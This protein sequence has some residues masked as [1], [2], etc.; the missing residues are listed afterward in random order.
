MADLLNKGS[1]PGSTQTLQRRVRELSML[2]DIARAVISVLDL[3]GVLNRIVDA[4]VFLTNAEEGFILLVDEE[5]DEFILR[6]GKGLGDKAAKVMRMKVKDTMAG[7]VVQTGQPLRIGGF[8]K[9]QEYKVKT[10]Y[11][12]KSLVNVP[13]KAQSRQVI[14]VLSVDH[15]LASMRT[16]SDHDVALLTS[17]ADYAAIAIENARLYEEANERAEYLANALEE[18]GQ[19]P[20]KPSVESDREDLEKFIQGLRAQREEV[21]FVQNRTVKMSQELR[22]QAN[23]VD[24]MSQRLALWDEEVNALMPALEWLAE[25][26]LTLAAGTDRTG[27]LPAASGEASPTLALS[28]QLTC[29]L[30]EGILL[31]DAKGQ[32][33]NANP[34]A[35]RL[36]DRSIEEIEG[37]DL[38]K[39]AVQ[40]SR[41]ERMVGSLRLALALGDSERPAP[42]S[43]SATLYF[44]GRAV[45]ATLVPFLDDEADNPV[46]IVAVLRDITAEIEGWRA[47]DEAIGELSE[48]IRSPLTAIASYSDLLLSESV[49]LLTDTQRRYLQRIRYSADRMEESLAEANES[50]A[51]RAFYPPAE[52]VGLSEALDDAVASAREE[53]SLAGVAIATDI[54]EELPPV[55]MAAEHITKIVGELLSLAGQHTPVGATLTVGLDSQLSEGQLSHLILGIRYGGH[56]DKGLEPLER[57]EDF[58]E[59]KT[60]AEEQGGRLWVDRESTGTGTISFL[61]PVTGQNSDLR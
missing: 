37:V 46:G 58:V 57:E 50:L 39:L 17:L 54:P 11:L 36:L 32:I 61:L 20:E 1:N 14:G 6:A 13:I 34:A 60:M 33:L 24:E 43:P 4:A 30:S 51:R 21:T 3:Q 26:G 31:C 42:P 41:W 9:D 8:R 5:S 53:L 2:H 15:S 29:H 56:Q 38:Q 18:A 22:A 44:G 40:D 52:A 28:R 7:K 49:G 16:F 35:A 19:M 27:S 48:S 45:L 47:R 23:L 55:D 59:I 10:G 25:T 12:V